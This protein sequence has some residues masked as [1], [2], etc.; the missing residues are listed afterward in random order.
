MA[1]IRATMVKSGVPF[2][3]MLK[4]FKGSDMEKGLKAAGSEWIHLVQTGDNSAMMISCYPNKTQAN[5]AW[6][7]SAAFRAE[8]AAN[9]GAVYWPVE[10]PSKWSI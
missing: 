7:A 8:G 3:Q 5:K 9:N 4:E 6:K 2:S 1:Y 10:G